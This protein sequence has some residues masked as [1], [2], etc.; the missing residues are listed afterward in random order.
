[1]FAENARQAWLILA[2]N[3]DA[4]YRKSNQYTT[5]FVSITKIN[6]IK[7]M[8]FPVDNFRRSDINQI[9][10]WGLHFGSAQ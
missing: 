3:T 2:E 7:V 10:L 6:H 4:Y 1:M 8:V 9:R 5:K